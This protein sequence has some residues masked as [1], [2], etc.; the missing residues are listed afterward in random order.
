MCV[1]E[2]MHVMHTNLHERPTVANYGSN[3]YI[4]TYIHTLT[5]MLFQDAECASYNGLVEKDDLLAKAKQV[6]DKK[7]KLMAEVS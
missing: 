6:Q 4:H 3:F 5:L 2:R 7:K 1:C